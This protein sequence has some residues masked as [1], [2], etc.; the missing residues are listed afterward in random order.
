MS[1]LAKA[2]FEGQL[3][4]HAISGDELTMATVTDAAIT[5]EMASGLI[6]STN[7][8]DAIEESLLE[9]RVIQKIVSEGHY[10]HSDIISDHLE[11]G[12]HADIA[13]QHLI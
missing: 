4:G 10:D 8:I 7:G 5:A 6:P 1:D 13:S 12:L 9:A 11:A 2:V 3:I